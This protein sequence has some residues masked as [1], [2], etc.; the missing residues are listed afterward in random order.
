MLRPNVKP[1]CIFFRNI[2]KDHWK[3]YPKIKSL[4][5]CPAQIRAAVNC[6]IEV[7]LVENLWSNIN[8]SRILSLLLLDKFIVYEY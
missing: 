8:Q 4:L 5:P 7:L 2:T 3:Y 1:C 6:P